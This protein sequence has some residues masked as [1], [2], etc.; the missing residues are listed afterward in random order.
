MVLA[1]LLAAGVACSVGCDDDDKS[2]SGGGACKAWCDQQDDCG[3]M[4]GMDTERCEE[5][6]IEW[7]ECMDKEAESACYDSYK[8]WLNCASD[9]SCSDLED[10]FQDVCKA[11]AEKAY[12]KCS[13][14]EVNKIGDSC[15]ER[16]LTDD[17]I[18]IWPDPYDGDEEG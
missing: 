8:D 14:S 1:V 6:C 18:A 4:A 10:D 12:G 15:G 3:F 5:D 2:V 7:L 9:V 16:T 17:F 11:K 13:M